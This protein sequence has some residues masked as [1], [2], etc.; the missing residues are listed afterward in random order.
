MREGSLLTEA[1]EGE[2]M[3]L[4]LTEEEVGQLLSMEE[5]LEAVEEAFKALGRGEAVN[6]P[7]SRVAMP[8]GMLHVMPAGLLPR[9]AMGFKAYTV[10]KN[11]AR[12]LFLLYDGEGRLLSIMEAD[13]LGQ[14]RTG[15]AT[16]VAT[17]HMARPEAST[18][19][20]LG[21]G[22]Q[23]RAQ[24]QA[25]ALV[26]PIR[27]VRAY[28]RNPER[29]RTFCREMGRTLGI[30]II[31][32][33]RPEAVIED[34]DI[35]V[36]ITTAKDPVLKGD[37]LLPGVHINAA[38]S[39]FA[40]KREL[41]EEAVRKAAFIAVDSKEQARIESGD[42]LVPIEKGLLGWEDV[43]ELGE[44]VAGLVPGRRS[45]DEITLFKSHGIALEDVAV[46]IRVYERAK[47]EG[48]GREVPI[49]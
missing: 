20:I 40:H 15:A 9:Q 16:G 41:D 25:I 48:V 11:G 46:A 44:V 45:P 26:R 29:R 10:S 12:F 13:R 3:A 14:I 6:R 17:R 22:W 34:A 37:W 30:E 42:L 27:R 28:G 4:F 1:V 35:V 39:N 32:V 38:G 43:H 5:A 18:V 21:T 33:E 49:G 19:G 24:L 31:P 23:A 47:A 7:R 2:G 36:T 8:A